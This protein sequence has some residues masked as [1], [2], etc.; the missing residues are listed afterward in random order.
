MVVA[1][2]LDQVWKKENLVVVKTL[3]HDSKVLS[4]AAG[5]GFLAT[6][7]DDC[8]IKLWTLSDFTEKATLQGHNWEVWQLG[9]LEGFLLSGSFD[10][11]IKVWF[12]KASLNQGVEFDF[13][14]V[15]ENTFRTQR[16]YPRDL[17]RL[18]LKNSL[19]WLGRQ[20]NQSLGRGFE[21]RLF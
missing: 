18:C 13:L 15:C 2:L 20:N 5:E 12:E 3:I 9:F 6:G 16:V 14:A 17:H 4:I 8:K 19:F 10:H 21:N 11:T 1:S 7:S